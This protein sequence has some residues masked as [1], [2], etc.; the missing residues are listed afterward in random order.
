AVI[1]DGENAWEHYPY[2]GFYFFEDLYGLL[3]KHPKIRTTTF[4]EL[5]RRR[6]APAALPGLTA[7]SWVYGTL[8]TWIGDA[9]KNRAWEYLCAAKQAYDLVLGS[10][11]LSGDEAAAAERQLTVCESSDWF[12]WFGD[13]NPA[14]AVA[15][16]DKLFRRNLMNLYRLLQ[17]PPPAQLNEPLSRGSTD[18]AGTG[19]MRRATEESPS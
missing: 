7:G 13:Y 8:S 11:R 3:E 14:Q 17:L 15:S 18:A 16:F 1:L 10:G 12:W 5:L 19:A 6:S 9:E 4:S 2:N